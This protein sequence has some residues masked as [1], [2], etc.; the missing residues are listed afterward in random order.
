MQLT[1]WIQ[2]RKAAERVAESTKV[3]LQLR[4]HP[5]HRFVVRLEPEK[6]SYQIDE[7]VT[8]RMEIENVGKTTFS[9]WDGGMQRGPRNNQFGFMAYRG[10][11]YGRAVPDI[12]DPTNFGGMAG[13]EVLKPGDT[14]T[15]EVELSKWFSLETADTYRIIGLFRMT[16]GSPSDRAAA[17]D[18]FAVAECLVKVVKKDRR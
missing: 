8:L 3:T 4:E 7:V 12:G 11:G 15:K 5:G 18:D 10:H 13:Q 16:V 17:W 1:G 9:F 14:F 6:D 2:G